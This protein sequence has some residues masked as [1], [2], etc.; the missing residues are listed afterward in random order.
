MR[1]RRISTGPPRPD[2]RRDD[3][4]AATVIA[5]LFTVALLAV[6]GLVIDGGYALGAKRQAMNTAEQ[7]ARVGAD[8]LSPSALRDGRT[9][10]DPRQAVAAA[11][12]YLQSV[13]AEGQVSVNG[14]EVTVTV[15]DRQETALLSAVG[16]DSIPVEATSTAR[17]IDQDG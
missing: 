6:A 7:A 2:R 3:R 9:Q 8:A 13:G 16:V 17:S 5:V 15:V 1:C 10:V 4:G 11:R 14:G 12:S